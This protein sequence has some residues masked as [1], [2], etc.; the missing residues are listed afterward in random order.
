MTEPARRIADQ[1]INYV[2]N[3]PTAAERVIDYASP[4]G[5]IAEFAAS[6]GLTIDADQQ[7]V[8]A[9][10]LVAA[11]QTIIDRSMHTTH[12]RFFNQNFAGPEP[13]AV[14]GDWLAAALNTTNA[15]FEVA[16]VFTM[17]ERAVIA[18]M[19]GLAGYP[20]DAAANALPPGILC[21]GGSSGTLH[22]LQLARHRLRPDVLQSGATGERLVVFVSDTAHYATLKSAALMGLGLQAV[23]EVDTDENG[24]MIAAELAAAVAQARV[25]GAAPFAVVATAGTTVTSAFDPL[26]PIADICEAENLWLHVDGCWGGSALFSPQQA[27]LMEGV[28]RSDSLVWN[29]HKMMGITQQC[30]VLLVKDPSQF[31]PVFSTNATYIFQADKQFGEYDAGDRTFHCGR[32]VDVLKA[33]LTWKTFG[34]DGFA[35]RVDHAV[36]LADHTRAELGGRNDFAIV[37][38]GSF[39]NVCFVWVPPELQ[40]LDITT[41]S[42]PDHARLHALAARIKARMQHDG[43][44]MIGF[45]P[46][47]GINAFRLLYMNRKVA[48][49]DVDAV[50]DLIANYGEQEWP[51]TVQ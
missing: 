11:C 49:V 45:Q 47:N 39:T 43:T 26:D 36:A 42:E 30:S 46:V 5:L 29:L 24:A 48:T 23:V 22:A 17:M 34:D 44:A 15:T 21:P 6:V 1:A 35:E 41:L 8:A 14:V 3:P 12:P 16:P 7:A 10:A 28:H 19:A 40:P 31:A 20:V 25:E 9:D 38:P 37:V 4:D 27:G 2:F 33:W 50:L 13:I 32:R 18:K 51:R